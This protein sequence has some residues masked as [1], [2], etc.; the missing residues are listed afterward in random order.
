MLEKVDPQHD[1][2]RIGL[3]AVPRG[4]IVRLDQRLEPLPRHNAIHLSQKR[5]P[6]GDFPLL[7]E[8]IIL[9]ETALH[10]IGSP[11]LRQGNHIRPRVA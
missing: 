5:F 9:G 3:P 6:P 1:A 4:G 7:P 2:Q 8:T 11:L 10:P